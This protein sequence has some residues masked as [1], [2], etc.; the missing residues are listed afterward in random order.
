[1][2]STFPTNLEVSQ[3]DRLAKASRTIIATCKGVFP[4]TLFPDEIFLDENKVEIVYHEFFFQRSISTI[5]LKDIKTVT[6]SAGPFFASIQFEIS[7][8]E[9]NPPP[10]NFLPKRSA[11]HLR[12]AIIGLS[13][14]KKEKIAYETLPHQQVS[15]KADQIGAS[16]SSLH[17]V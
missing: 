5:L 11:L 16:K 14:A 8:Y 6:V 15:K 12:D 7:G 10:I 13:I 2:Y 1:M 4:F 3:L 17:G 9:E